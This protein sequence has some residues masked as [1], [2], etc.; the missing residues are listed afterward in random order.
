MRRMS[1]NTRTELEQEVVDAIL[2]SKAVNFEAM[3]SII[4]KYGARAAKSGISLVTIINKNI[5]INCG[6]PGPEIGR[7]QLQRITEGNS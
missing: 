4:S 2:E 6:W 1:H 5:I 7:A 3:G